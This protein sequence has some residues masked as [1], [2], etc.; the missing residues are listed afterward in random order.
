[1]MVWPLEDVNVTDASGAAGVVLVSAYNGIMV[2][3][4]STVVAAGTAAVAVPFP[5]SRIIIFA[6]VQVLRRHRYLVVGQVIDDVGVAQEAGAEDD[7]LPSRSRRI[8]PQ[9]AIYR[10]VILT[11]EGRQADVEVEV[12]QGECHIVVLVFHGAGDDAADSNA[13]E[14]R[15]AQIS[16]ERANHRVGQHDHG[17]AGVQNRIGG[18]VGV[19]MARGT[20]GVV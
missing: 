17:L 1:M 10:I 6:G 8:D 2:H 7:A 3:A 4:M 16:K 18:H 14:V 19:V 20:G 9:D 12:G 11:D 15:G 5:I 13:G